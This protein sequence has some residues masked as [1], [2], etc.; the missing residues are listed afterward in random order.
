MKVEYWKLH[1]MSN[2]QYSS[3]FLKSITNNS[4]YNWEIKHFY[5]IVS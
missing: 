2:R 3:W 1:E 5:L 4:K